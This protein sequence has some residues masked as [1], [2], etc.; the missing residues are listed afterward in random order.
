MR[1]IFHCDI[2]NCFASIEMA[3]NP[4]L[5]GRAIAVCGDPAQRRGIVLAK[6]EPA[7]KCGVKT[8]D[9]LW[10]AKQKCP[11]I[12]FITPHYDI[13]EQY[14]MNIR[15]YY[16]QFTP[17]VEPFGIDECWLDVTSNV[18]GNDEMAEALAHHIR[19]NIR[20]IFDV[21]I[22][23]GI[24]FNRIFAKLG[25]DMKKPDA[26]TH[27]KYEDFRQKTW[28]L[29]VSSL[30]GVGRSTSQKLRRIGILTIGDLAQSQREFIRK[31][32]GKCGDAL[33]LYANGLDDSDVCTE[34]P[35][36]QSLGHG[37]TLPQDVFSCHELWPT[38]QILAERIAFE[39]LDEGFLARGIQI[40][41]R[42]NQL[43]FHEFQHELP[44][45]L[46]AARVIAD[47]SLMM[48]SQHYDWEFGIRAFGIRLFHLERRDAARQLSL[49]ENTALEA[50]NRAEGRVDTAIRDIQKRFGSKSIDRGCAFQP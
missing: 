7:K 4:S 49:F 41:V 9:P 5:K 45:D 22:S 44:F 30:L 23:V 14:S 2:N 37:T 20:R 29:P 46:Y 28:C 31:Q 36:R 32:L 38:I 42:D 34:R 39:L 25:S 33:W 11:Q 27:I 48:L 8:G 10:M 50:R 40:Y 47:Y 15:Q 21:T 3:L 35:P 24:S 26:V 13:Y 17:F 1:T 6:S 12:L 16:E 43:R 19:L 18:R